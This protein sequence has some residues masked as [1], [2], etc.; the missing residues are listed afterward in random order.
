[1]ARYKVRIKEP[2]ACTNEWCETS[3]LYLTANNKNE[4]LKQAKQ[5]FLGADIDE[6]AVIIS[7]DLDK[8]YIIRHAAEI[9]RA[10]KMIQRYIYNGTWTSG[11]TTVVYPITLWVESGEIVVQ[12]RNHKNVFGK[13]IERIK[14][15]SNGLITNGYFWKSDGSCPST[16][17]FFVNYN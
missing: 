9:I 8:Q 5:Y 4:A 11:S 2:I 16:I 13:L 15:A 1:M 6:T 10:D 12:L 17:K 7:I 3:P 14:E